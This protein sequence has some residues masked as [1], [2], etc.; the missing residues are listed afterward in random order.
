MVRRQAQSAVRSYAS[1][2]VLTIRDDGFGRTGCG[3][4]G[5]KTHRN[6]GPFP[7]GYVTG[8]R[9]RSTRIEPVGSIDR[10][11]TRWTDGGPRRGIYVIGQPSDDFTLFVRMVNYRYR[12]VRTRRRIY[13]ARVIARIGTTHARVVYTYSRV[14]TRRRHHVVRVY[15]TGFVGSF[16]P[17]FSIR[18]VIPP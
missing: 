15:R 5:G 12:A 4:E 11:R 13:G 10:P 6:N 2:A 8:G 7:F 3:P 9:V 18:H 14:C 16:S 17:S 1:S